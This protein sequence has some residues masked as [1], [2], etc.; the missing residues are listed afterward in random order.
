MF[1]DFLYGVL[2]S[3]VKQT[4]NMMVF[5]EANIP[6][7]KFIYLL[8]LEDERLSL[9]FSHIDGFSRKMNFVLLN[10]NF[11]VYNWLYGYLN[12]LFH[13]LACPFNQGIL[14]II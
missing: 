11:K 3:S 2:L 7:W 14:N 10:T 1:S 5:K 13:P 9:K 12:K 6:Q 4:Q 8:S